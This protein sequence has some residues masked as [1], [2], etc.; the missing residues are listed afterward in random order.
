MEA[1][2]KIT[3]D[4][5]DEIFTEISEFKKRANITDDQ[6]AVFELLRYALSFPEYFRNYDWE[7]AEKEADEEIASGRVKTFSSADELLSE[8]NA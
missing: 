7:R 6:T 3:L 2:H 4:I 1:T 8:L 5:P